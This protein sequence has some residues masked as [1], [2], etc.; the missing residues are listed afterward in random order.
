MDGDNITTDRFVNNAGGPQIKTCFFFL[1]FFLGSHIDISCLLF[2]NGKEIFEFQPATSTIIFICTHS[3]L[4]INQDM[5]IMKVK[6]L[7][8]WLTIRASRTRQPVDISIKQ[9]SMTGQED[10]V[11]TNTHIK[12][13]NDQRKNAIT[14][15]LREY[16]MI[17]LI[18]CDIH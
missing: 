14:M 12:R 3:C 9:K 6:V 15:L 7:A 1:Y 16:Q 13:K 5:K 8:A 11:A 17:K 4:T 10:T 2:T 18:H